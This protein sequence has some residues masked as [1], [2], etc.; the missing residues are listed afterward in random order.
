LVV[1]LEA[2]T[3][4]RA[5]GV[6][7]HW[8]V[9]GNGPTVV[10]AHHSLWSYP[11]LYGDLIADLSQDR[12]VIVYDPR[13][14][15]QSSREGPYDVETD[16]ADFEA[17]V[18]A[19]GGAALALSIGEGLNRTVRVADARPDLIPRVFSIVPGAAAVLPQ[20]ELKGSGVMAASDSVIDMLRQMMATDP[21]AALRMMVGTVNPGLGEVE[22]RERVAHVADYLSPE[23]ALQRAEAWLA[24]DV[25]SHVKALGDRI[26][27]AHGGPD[28]MFEGALR[29]RVEELFP[30]AR[31]ETLEDGPISRPEMTAA[32]VRELTG[33]AD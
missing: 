6:E 27:I 28:P 10:I 29:A 20:A 12:R 14:S 8:E 7:I 21:R 32:R 18:E 25:V 23:A 22:L 33:A 30:E 9:R 4:E 5:E 13:G 2:H 17:V 15:G 24:D 11:E 16:A 26:S 19:A 31:L 1:T 3:L